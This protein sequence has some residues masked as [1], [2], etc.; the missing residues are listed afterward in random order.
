MN[1]ENV[2][3]EH[4][5]EQTP[6]YATERD[7]GQT[8]LIL[9]IVVAVVASVVMLFTDSNNALKIALLAALWAAIVGFFLVYRYRSQAKEADARN[10]LAQQLH[11]AELKQARA[12]VVP[13]GRPAEGDGGDEGLNTQLLKELREEI[14]GLRAQLEELSGYRFDY[15][16]EAI[17]A[18]AKRIMEVEARAANQRVAEEMASEKAAQEAASPA[19][20]PAAAAAE[21]EPE[22][23]VS[24][25]ETWRV[26][27]TPVEEETTGWGLPSREESPNPFT[28]SSTD[29]AEQPAVTVTDTEQA[30]AEESHRRPTGAPSVDAVAGRVGRQDYQQ[31]SGTNPLSALI[32]ENSRR[33]AEPVESENTRRGGRR[34]RDENNTGVSV[35]DLMKNLKKDPSEGP[36]EGQE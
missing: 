5:P 33:E 29:T 11:A 13:V 35:A 30:S 24:P 28:P 14:A 4:T 12:Q 18:E 27:P 1:E 2:A 9:L 20:T 32:T 26:Q 8:A 31:Q 16:P 21:P 22:P 17:R 3:G 34:R 15:E 7:A 10:T 23:A 19:A 36:G 25:T 6:E